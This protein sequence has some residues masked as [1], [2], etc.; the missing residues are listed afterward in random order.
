MKKQIYFNSMSDRDLLS[1]VCDSELMAND[2][3]KLADRNLVNLGRLTVEDLCQVPGIGESKATKILAIME[4]AR[5]MKYEQAPVK[6][7]IKQSMDAYNLLDSITGM[8]TMSHE[9]FHILLLD[10]G[11]NVIKS[12]R[13]SE[14]GIS[15]TVTDVRI[16]LNHAIKSMASGLILA[17]NHPSGNLRPSEA[18]INIT[19]KIKEA[20]KLL[21]ISLLDHL[22]LSEQGYLSMA[23]DNLIP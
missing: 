14:G 7:K 17:H 5:R 4:L 1:M 6:P 19:R 18:D 21:D 20:C 3:I 9:E 22:I 23:D 12:V 10:R 8:S 16:I 15:G 11:N 2:V 13:I